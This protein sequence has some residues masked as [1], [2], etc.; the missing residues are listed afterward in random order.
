MPIVKEPREVFKA[1]PVQK[2]AGPSG[3]PNGLA[4]LGAK[5]NL[6]RAALGQTAETLK[7]DII[8]ITGLQASP[9]QIEEGLKAYFNEVADGILASTFEAKERVSY[10]PGKL[11]VKVASETVASRIRNKSLEI[12]RYIASRTKTDAISIDIS[13]TELIIESK[14]PYTDNERLQYFIN[15][16]PYLETFIQQL[17]LV[18]DRR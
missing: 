8:P 3:L 18:P 9:S 14:V 5:S 1:E 6:L 11:L 16:N 2:V 13:V 4:G 12:T 17:Q 10:L 7:S 15:K